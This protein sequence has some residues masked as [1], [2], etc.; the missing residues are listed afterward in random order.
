M[1]MSRITKKNMKTDNFLVQV[2]ILE[3]NNFKPRKTTIE[4]FPS[5][6]GGSQ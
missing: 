2:N 3:I 6:H 1:N 4:I 5:F